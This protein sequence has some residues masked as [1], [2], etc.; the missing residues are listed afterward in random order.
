MRESCSTMRWCHQIP[1]APHFHEL[2]E[3]GGI[4]PVAVGVLEG[5][6]TADDVDPVVVVV[7]GAEDGRGSRGGRR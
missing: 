5:T 1:T 3:F 7:A 2:G 4:V 6:E